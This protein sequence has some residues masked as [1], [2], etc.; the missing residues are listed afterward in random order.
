MPGPSTPTAPDGR[1]IDVRRF[2]EAVGLALAERGTSQADLARQAGLSRSSVSRYLS[3]ALT[4]SRDSAQRI[5]DALD[6]AWADVTSGAS[7]LTHDVVLVPR[8]GYASG[9]RSS[10]EGYVNSEGRSHGTAL[11]T[12]DPSESHDLYA[13]DWL[14]RVIGISPER[15]RSCMVVGDSLAPEVAPN[16]QVLYIPVEEYLGDGLYLL[17]IDDAH[18]VKRVQRFADGALELLPYNPAYK[19]ETLA[20]LK[21]ADTPNT[22]RTASGT[23]AVVRFVGKVVFYPK[24]A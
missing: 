5:L 16:T 20:P 23:T 7:A 21:E 6:L 11:Q 1:P 24:A 8:D 10:G 15:C 2:S 22:Y 9:A 3:G 19:P 18:V 13:R 17:A 14:R 12:L 4:P